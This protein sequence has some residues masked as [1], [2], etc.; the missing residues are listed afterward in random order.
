MHYSID[1]V[2]GDSFRVIYSFDIWAYLFSYE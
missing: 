2:Q 1:N